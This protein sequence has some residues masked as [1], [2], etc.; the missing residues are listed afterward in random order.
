[1]TEKYEEECFHQPYL[2]LYAFGGYG[3]ATLVVGTKIPKFGGFY[4]FFHCT[5][6]YSFIHSFIFFFLTANVKMHS[7]LQII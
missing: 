4:V 5:Q 7:L 3:L 2:K 1:M 6:Q